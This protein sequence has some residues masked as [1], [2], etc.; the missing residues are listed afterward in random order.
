MD[1]AILI[2][3]LIGGDEPGRVH[4]LTV[5]EIAQSGLTLSGHDLGVAEALAL[6]DALGDLPEMVL[7]LGVE[8]SAPEDCAPGSPS[9]RVGN[10]ILDELVNQIL[11]T[12]PCCETPQER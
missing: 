1:G 6:G 12:V 5:E 7:I 4:P 11:A 3:A 2:D 9:P 8:V 10:R